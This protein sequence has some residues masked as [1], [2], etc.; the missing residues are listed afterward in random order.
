MAEPMHT[1][2]ICNS[3]DDT[4]EVLCAVLTLRGYRCVSAHV[5]DIK[6][7]KMDFGAFL[8]RE[9]PRVIVWDIALPYDHNWE[10]FQSLR[11]SGAFDS[12]GIVLTTTHKANLEKVIGQESGALE[13]LLKP[14]DVAVICDAVEQAAGSA[15]SE[16][17]EHTQP[18]VD[19]PDAR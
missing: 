15:L 5:T 3:S 14:Y 16:R 7:G 19:G 4:I 17:S 10:F 13:V 8:T 1:V 9:D 12:R 11:A 6:R 18:G 2:A